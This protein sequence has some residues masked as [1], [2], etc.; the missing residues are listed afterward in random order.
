[1]PK[2][3]DYD[4][5]SFK[6]DVKKNNNSQRIST[7]NAMTRIVCFQA[8]SQFTIPMPDKRHLSFDYIFSVGEYK[9]NLNCPIDYVL[10]V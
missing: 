1:M 7:P 4:A 8:V 9:V 3:L 10:P 5:F 6:E 2:T